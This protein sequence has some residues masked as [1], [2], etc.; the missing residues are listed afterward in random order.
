LL[1]PA[2]YA[3]S[4]FESGEI[5]SGDRLK[6]IHVLRAP[7]GGLFR[8]VIDLACAQAALGHH[9]GL[10][11]DS[12]TGGEAAARALRRVAPFL[13]LGVER[14]PMRR[15]PC[16]GDLAAIWRVHR[17][18]RRLQPDM[19]HGHGSKGGFF[20]R[21]TGFLPGPDGMARA[22]TPHGGSFHRQP[23]HGLYMLVERTVA[24][25]TDV[26]FFESDYIAAEVAKHVRPSAALRRV[27]KNGLRPDEF[28]PVTAQPDASEFVY[29]GELSSYKGVDTLIDALG[30]IHA[31]GPHKPSLAIVGSGREQ[32]RLAARVEARGL[33]RHVAFY[34][35]LPAREA[36][37]LG[38]I[39]VAPSRA[40]SLPYIVLESLA[41]EK[42]L[43]A[44]DVGGVSEIFGPHRARLIP[45]DRAD[46]LAGAMVGALERAP[47]AQAAESRALRDRVAAHFS[48]EE[49]TRA[50]LAGYRDAL[51]AK[52]PGKP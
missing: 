2:V 31:A 20:A 16:P 18:V 33:N 38:R 44:T 42:P 10:V 3:A 27:A 1:T 12:S 22:Y 35:V 50:V 43:I 15:E 24:A 11:A 51:A 21:A 26:L 13:A 19:L 45:R 4:G 5:L 9:V 37:T 30:A 48:V 39:V 36:F 23:G 29:V 40:E 17:L 6:I 41:A 46:L 25:K 47:D 49:M 32:N 52:T 7:V 14:F 34:G 28:A 8:H